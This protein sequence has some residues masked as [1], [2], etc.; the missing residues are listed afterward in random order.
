MT[1][2][3]ASA[4][5]DDYSDNSVSLFAWQGEANGDG[6]YTAAMTLPAV[7]VG[8]A[9]FLATGQAQERRIIDLLNYRFA[10]QANTAIDA[11][12]AAANGVDWDWANRMSV[13]IANVS[14]EFSVDGSL[15][16]AR[17]QIVADDKCNACH[18]PEY[19]MGRNS[20]LSGK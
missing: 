2:P 12:N 1:V 16:N 17:R 4:A 6:S 10:L 13:P 5:I 18:G 3:G 11:A 15:V 8:T 7:A 19:I 20:P 9:R 14:R